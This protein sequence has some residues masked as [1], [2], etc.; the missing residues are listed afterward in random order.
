M[1]GTGFKLVYIV[2]LISAGVL[3]LS[4][5]TL[6]TIFSLKSE[7]VSYERKLENIKSDNENLQRELKWSESEEG[8]VKYMVKDHLGLVEPGEKKLYIVDKAEKDAE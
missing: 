2:V 5:S 8:Y 3:Y 7:A 4:S 6:K 1:K